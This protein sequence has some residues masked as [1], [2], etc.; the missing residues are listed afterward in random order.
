MLSVSSSGR[1]V[2]IKHKQV[3][4]MQKVMVLNLRTLVRC[5]IWLLVESG[6]ITF[7]LQNKS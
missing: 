1:T 5:A 4:G 6:Y 2:T 3:Q 7:N